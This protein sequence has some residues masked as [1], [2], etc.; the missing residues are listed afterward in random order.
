MG[1]GNQGLRKQMAQRFFAYRM[2]I[3]RPERF[4][5][6]SASFPLPGFA[7]PSPPRVLFPGQERVY[8]PYRQGRAG[9]DLDKIP[10]NKIDDQDI[11]V[12]NA[13][14][15]LLR[16]KREFAADP[17]FLYNKCLGWGGMGLV[18]SFL[19]LGD[20]GSILSPVAVKLSFDE[21]W[22]AEDI[23]RESDNQN[24]NGCDI[25]VYTLRKAEH[26]VQ[27]VDIDNPPLSDDDDDMPYPVKSNL[28]RPAPKDSA[29]QV[30]RKR[31]R[32]EP[33]LATIVMEILENG[34]LMNFIIKVQAHGETIP[35]VV[36]GRFFLCLVRACIAMAYPPA[37][38]LENAGVP[39][40]IMETVPDQ[41]R[42]SPGRMVHFDIDPRNIFMGAES[43]DPASEHTLTPI[44]KLGDFGL[45]ST[46]DNGKP[47][48][49]YERM[50]AKG[51]IGFYAPESFCADWDYIPL[52]S[53]TVQN[54]PVAGNFRAHTNI[55]QIGLVMETL[56]TLCSPLQPPFA[57]RTTV[58]CPPNKESYHTYAYHLSEQEYSSRVDARIIGSVFRC[59]AHLPEDRPKL[60]ELEAALVDICGNIQQSY[61]MET[62]NRI[63]IWMNKILHHVPVDPVIPVS[64]TVQVSATPPR[65]PTATGPGASALPQ[66]TTVPETPVQPTGPNMDI[67]EID[68]MI[69]DWETHENQ[70]PGGQPSGPNMDNPTIDPMILNWETQGNQNPGGQPSGTPRD[71][72]FA[73][74]TGVERR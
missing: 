68:P 26:I 22:G 65:A 47:D 19:R 54:H 35:N 46:I 13:L 71:P 55:W 6:L 27:L 28:K 23:E 18:A 1:D 57:H 15:D 69:L 37:D 62:N 5:R 56:I 20:D 29:R 74:F 8:L 52:N 51:K 36:L 4:P 43:L 30:R 10:K 72:G 45:A 33:P 67:P 32:A 73:K 41:E 44:L 64:R 7:P 3:W 16:L 42:D 25:V 24:A 61:P 31:L 63:V 49:Y 39:G 11:T 70:D 59:Q 21:E 58:Q 53:N 66:M 38:R 40:P 14:Y 34:D 9:I 17:R 2:G 50:R 60:H 48:N 12:Q